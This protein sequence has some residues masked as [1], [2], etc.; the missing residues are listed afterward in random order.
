MAPTQ[1]VLKFTRSDDSSKYVLVNVT[2]KGPKPL[3]IKIQ[4]TEGDAEYALSR[5]STKHH[6]LGPSNASSHQSS[7]TRSLHYRSKTAQPPSQNGSSAW[8]F[9]SSRSLNRIFKPRPPS[10]MDPLYL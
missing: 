9:C 5:E 10:L 7:T 2:F 6:P 8:G 4:A 3:D 1:R